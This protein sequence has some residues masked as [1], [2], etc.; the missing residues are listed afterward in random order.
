MRAAMSLVRS[1][2]YQALFLPWTL[3]LGVLYL[4]LLLGPRLWTQRAAVIWIR[5]ALFLQRAVLGLGY[6]IR[7][8]E[9]L[10]AGACVLAVKHQSA[11]ETLIFHALLSDPAF[12]IKKSLL[13]LPVVGWY[14]W[15][16]GQIAIDRRAGRKALARMAKAGRAA[17]AEGRQVIVFPEGHRQPPGATGFYHPGITA[18][19]GDGAAPMIP[20]ALNSG[21][22]W[23]RNA[24]LRRPGT[25]VLEFLP[26]LPP[27]LDRRAVADELRSRIEP[28]TRA[29]EAEALARHPH[30]ASGLSGRAPA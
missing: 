16:S 29:L 13:W 10:P 3:V 1:A 19:Y 2:L 12:V 5:G 9:N 18:L 28:A 25:I 7:G 6:E 30:L 17:L 22:F 21:L 14:L 27:G 8:R 24:F 26:A 23:S 4:P 15:K 11:W 20:V